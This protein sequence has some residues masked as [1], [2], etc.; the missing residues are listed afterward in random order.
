MRVPR[1]LCSFLVLAFYGN[2]WLLVLKGD[3]VAPSQGHAIDHL[4][5]RPT[6]LDAAA[7]GS[8]PRA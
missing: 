2:I 7:V 5:F 3:G 8:R 1:L 4:G 6:N